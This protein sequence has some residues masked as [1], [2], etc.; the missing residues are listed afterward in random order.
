VDRDELADRARV[1]EVGLNEHPP[2]QHGDQRGDHGDDAHRLKITRVRASVA[3]RSIA[4]LNPSIVQGRWVLLDEGGDGGVYIFVF[5]TDLDGSS[6]GDSWVE[7]TLA[8]E[9]ASSADEIEGDWIRIGA[10]LPYCQQD[11]VWPVRVAGRESGD[12]R[13]GELERLV[14]GKWVPFDPKVD[15]VPTVEEA[16]REAVVLSRRQ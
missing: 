5:A 14:D 9:E 10:P 16:I 12:P 6:T 1:H 8:E 13:F 15:V 11:W 2:A 7:R 3:M 4:R